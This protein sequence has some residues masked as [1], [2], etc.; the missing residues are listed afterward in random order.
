[1]WRV[2]VVAHIVA[3][4]DDNVTSDTWISSIPLSA[5]EYDF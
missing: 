2:R 4:F 1:V 5:A 3:V